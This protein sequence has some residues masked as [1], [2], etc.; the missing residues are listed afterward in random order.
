MDHKQRQ[1]KTKTPESV[2]NDRTFENDDATSEVLFPFKTTAV[3][4]TAT[5]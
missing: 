2:P 5:I 4:L 1:N 3:D